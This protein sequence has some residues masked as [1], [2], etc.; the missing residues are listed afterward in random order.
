MDTSTIFL[1]SRSRMVVE[2]TGVSAGTS[3]VGRSWVTS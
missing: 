2:A 1:P 3:W